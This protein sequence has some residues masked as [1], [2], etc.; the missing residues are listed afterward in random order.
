MQE[1]PFKTLRIAGDSLAVD[2]HADRPLVARYHHL[3]S[4]TKIDGAG[5]DGTLLINGNSVP[6]DEWKIETSN[7]PQSAR[8]HLTFAGRTPQILQ[9]D[10]SFR[11]AISFALDGDSLAIELGDIEDPAGQLKTLSWRNAPL[12]RCSDSKFH[13]WRVFTSEPD[14]GGKMWMKDATGKLETTPVDESEVPVIWGCLWRPDTTCVAVSTNYPLFPLTHRIV[15]GTAYE[16]SLN[17]YQYRVR[18]KKMPPLKAQVEFLPDINGDGKTDDS[19]YRLLENR[20]LRTPDP[21]HHTHISYRILNDWADQGGLLT[22]IRQSEE[23]IK[24]IYN[25]TD[26]LPQF[27][28]LTGWQYSGH[29]TGYPA[30]DKINE[31]VGSREEFRN[32]A[33]TCKERYNTILSYHLNIDDSY[34]DNP[35]YD[36]RFCTPN[37]ICHTIDVETGEVFRRFEDT[38]KTIPVEKVVHIDNMRITNTHVLEE[39]LNKGIGI[40]EELVC[41]IMPIMKWLNER[42]ITVT[43]EG[44]NGAPVDAS[45]I[46]QGL[47]HF[48]PVLPVIQIYHQK[49][50]GGG[51][52]TRETPVPR[53]EFAVVK[54]IHQDFTWEPWPAYPNIVSMRADWPNIVDRIYRGTL[55][56]HFYLEHE[57]TKLER[58]DGGVYMEFGNGEVIAESANNHVSV[59]WKGVTVAEDDDRFIPRGNALYCYSLDGTNRTWALPPSFCDRNLEVFSLSREGRGPAPAYR[60]AGDQ[61]ELKL[62]PRTPVKI[63]ADDA[64]CE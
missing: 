61:I 59:T 13:F 27:P 40:L 52:G 9:S 4:G 6:W 41:G 30:M 48:D 11:F 7:T 18:K 47:W 58:V 3:A 32:L 31:R 37:G 24:A 35:G 43:T 51:M 56:Y 1:L 5:R 22:D 25:V 38:F 21:I 19:D 8:Y 42:G 60:L 64:E 36:P 10:H 20:K 28:Y 49:V 14:A 15:E 46:V 17:T 23:M 26:G 50:T 62:A 16:I 44:Q 55:L 63:V 12:V 34:R 54:G 29:D 2:L 33:R 39:Y 45:L 57:M 53:C